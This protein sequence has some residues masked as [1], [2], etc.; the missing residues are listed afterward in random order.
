MKKSKL[1]TSILSLA[2]VLTL[3]ACLEN[4]ED[5]DVSEELTSEESSPNLDTEDTTQEDTTS[6]PEPYTGDPVLDLLNS[7]KEESNYS[8]R[9]EYQDWKSSTYAD[10]EEMYSAFYSGTIIK[11]F[12]YDY[13]INLTYT[14]DVFLLEYYNNGDYGVNDA[15]DVEVYVNTESGLDVYFL[16]DNYTTNLH[17]YTTYDGYTW[18]TY[19]SSLLTL[20]D[21]LDYIVVNPES[22]DKVS[23]DYTLEIETLDLL[24]TFV[25]SLFHCGNYYPDDNYTKSAAPFVVNYKTY[26][27]S[28]G[29]PYS[30]SIYLFDT[31]EWD[32]TMYYLED[33]GSGSDHQLY[34]FSASSF[35][36]DIG[37]SSIDSVYTSQFN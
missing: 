37:N 6:E 1:L 8:L 35:V 17:E 12:V 10:E 31:E 15:Y 34:Y 4:L 9:I 29:A 22:Y 3:G 36:Y 27:E 33:I 14:E 16:T 11:N 2:L 28:Y 19:F 24:T 18:Q 30:D 32:T 20:L 5:N 26:Y 7:V 13:I 23:L 25:E 21:Y